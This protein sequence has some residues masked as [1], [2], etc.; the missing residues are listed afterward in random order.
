MPARLSTFVFAC[1][2]ATLQ[3]AAG[4]ERFA[5]IKTI[6]VIY[7]VRPERQMRSPCKHPRRIRYRETACRSQP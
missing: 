6:V 1:I 7:S 4:Q 2:L 5:K 3:T